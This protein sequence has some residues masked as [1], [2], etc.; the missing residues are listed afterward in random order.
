MA[1]SQFWAAADSAVITCKE[2]KQEKWGE[3]ETARN[4]CDVIENTRALRG[5]KAKHLI[6]PLSPNWKDVTASQ[7]CTLPCSIYPNCP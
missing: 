4:G 5:V 7:R 1:A 3:E 6:S 2:T